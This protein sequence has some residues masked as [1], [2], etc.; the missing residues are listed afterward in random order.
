MPAPG[1]GTAGVLGGALVLAGLGFAA[2]SLLVAGIALCL[3]AA[4]AAVWVELAASSRRVERAP[5]PARVIEGESYPLRIEATGGLVPPP[6]GE[7]RDPLLDEPVAVGPR[8]DGSVSRRLELTGRGRR[9]LGPPV[10]ELRDPLGLRSRVVSGR[11]RGDLLVLPRIEPIRVS[12]RGSQ[13]RRL[14][15]L[16]GVEESGMAS[17]HDAR[18]IEMEVDGLRRYREGSSASRIHWPAVART[19]E[20]IERRLVAGADSGPLVVLDAARP[21]DGAALDAAVRAAASLAF[22]LA[23][24]AGCSIL[25][26][27][28]RRP[29]ELERER[30]SWAQVHARL[31]VVE[32]G[33]RTAALARAARAGAIFWVTAEPSPALPV[34]L[35]PSGV[36]PRYLVA[37]SG[38]MRGRPEF[39]VAG[40]DGRLVGARAR[41]PRPVRR[42]A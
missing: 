19:G 37:P 26:P 39:T 20:L 30:R 13:G 11:R 33:M 32:G 35:R 31:A 29:V 36:G 6:G 8:W 23:A 2:P 22:H 21:A 9:I 40:C 10:L 38:H 28:E 3:L 34:S 15:A 7:L 1:A 24:A 18:S 25:L 42:A 14:G 17:V 27:G 5:G 12:G 41:S 16:A 4:V